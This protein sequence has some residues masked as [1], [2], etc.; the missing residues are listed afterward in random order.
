MSADLVILIPVLRRPH[1]VAPLL[2]S[3]REAT[4]EAHVVFLADPDDQE[5]IDA[6][7]AEQRDLP[8]SVETLGG[9]YASKVNRGVAR[10]DEP[11]I[12]T[13]ADDLGFCSGWLEAATAGLVDG[14]EVVGVND[15]I[16]RRQE[17]IEHA[18]HFLVTRTYAERGT[19]DDAPGLLYEGY[20]HSWCDNE[21]IETAKARRAY[22]YAADAHVQHFHPMNGLAP[23]DEVYLKGRQRFH[24]DQRIFRRRRHLWA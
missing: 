24:E 5:E 6:I 20:D 9:N 2:E 13:A 1:R 3:I 18:T 17:R 16:D 22:A 19:I 8:I 23:D 11:L 15:L 4:P 21:F 12:F 14:I 10:T 7:N